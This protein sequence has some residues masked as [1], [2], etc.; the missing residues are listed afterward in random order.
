M[1][2]KPRKRPPDSFGRWGT[3]LLFAFCFSPAIVQAHGIP[4]AVWADGTRQLHVNNVTTNELV[5]D[6][7]EIASDSPGIGVSNPNDGVPAGTEL[8]LETRSGL[9]YWDGAQVAESDAVLTIE[10]PTVIDEYAVA[11]DSPPQAG[12]VWATYPG[13]VL[14]DADGYYTLASASEIV[15]AGIYGVALRVAAADF[16]TS[17]SFLLAF[18]FDDANV[19]SQQ[20]ELAGVAALQAMIAAPNPGDF[21]ADGTVNQADYVRWSQD[22]GLSVTAGTGA[23]GN[24]DGQ[25]NA[26]DYTIWRDAYGSVPVVGVSIVPEP[27][28][29]TSLLTLLA[30]TLVRCR[31]SNLQ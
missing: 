28:A 22:F 8:L 10:S 15:P 19:L 27:P 18:V 14:W 25:V 13:G 31:Q 4:L 17:D 1:N 16:V 7:F 9:L 12:L 23:D 29:F 5:D 3:G 26:A 11:H 21:N 6:G 2:E 20:Q 30:A 24:A